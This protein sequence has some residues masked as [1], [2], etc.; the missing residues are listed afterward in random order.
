[1]NLETFLPQSQDFKFRG[2]GK[3]TS[4]LGCNTSTTSKKLRVTVCENSLEL[5][6]ALHVLHLH[7]RFRDQMYRLL[8]IDHLKLR[9]SFN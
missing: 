7:N 8:I 4:K 3:M 2:G 5:N 1:M 9:E 6:R